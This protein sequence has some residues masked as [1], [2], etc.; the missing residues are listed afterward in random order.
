MSRKLFL[1]LFTALGFFF[2]FSSCS[3]SPS[4]TLLPAKPPDTLILF[5]PGYKGS[6]LVDAKSGRLVWISSRDSLSGTRSIRLPVPGLGLEPALDLVPD[7]VLEEVPVLPAVFSLDIYGSLLNHLRAFSSPP[8]EVVAFAYDWRQP[9]ERTAARLAQK[10]DDSHRR[11]IK[12]VWLVGHSQ[13]G[14]IVSYYLRYGGQPAASAVENWAGAEAVDRVAIAGVPYLGTMTA[15]RSMNKG[16]VV[17]S[18]AKILAADATGTFPSA[19]YL[20]P[21]GEEDVLY[22]PPPQSKPIPGAIRD[23]HQWAKRHWGLLGITPAGNAQE[24]ENREAY[25]I[26]VI[27]E[28]ERFLS[29]IRAPLVHPPTK[30]I[31]LLYLYS[32]A[33]RTLAHAIWDSEANGPGS[34]VFDREDVGARYPAANEEKLFEPGD[35]L[36]TLRS[37]TLPR[38]YGDALSVTQIERPDG[39]RELVT[40]PTNQKRILD[41]ISL[42]K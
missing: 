8:C 34:L 36:I 1:W 3:H 30:R 5:V 10:I 29:R 4:L 27:D 6:R 9:P 26:Q 25:T 40:E 28:G 38:A 15:F 31:A 20:L 7:G 19:Y 41:F 39:H 37:A 13:G 12:H 2:A 35:G 24:R 18:N 16:D 22:S 21:S 32:R 42:P 17:A 33:H 14:L 23:S 11:G